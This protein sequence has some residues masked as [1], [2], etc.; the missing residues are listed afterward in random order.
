MIIDHLGIHVTDLQASKAFYLEALAPLGISLVIE[1]KYA[2]GLG[3]G[4]KPELWLHK[5]RGEASRLHFAFH[6]ANRQE[7]DDFYQAALAA[8]GQD[9]GPPGLREQYHPYYYGAF[10]LDPDGNNI[11]AVCHLPE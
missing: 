7:V 4:G 6:A 10:I 9:N 8:G 3:K 1:F 5:A 11:E 2:A